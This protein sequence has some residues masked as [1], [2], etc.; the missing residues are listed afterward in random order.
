MPCFLKMINYNTMFSLTVTELNFFHFQK[1]LVITFKM[2]FIF[3][4]SIKTIVFEC[5][6]T[7]M[8][9]AFKYCAFYF[10]QM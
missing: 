9:N 6:L 5:L 7:P 2:L 4:C 1:I 8:V 10:V 3:L